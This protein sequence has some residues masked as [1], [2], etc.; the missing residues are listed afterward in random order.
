M[1]T[2]LSRQEQRILAAARRSGE[3]AE[4]WQIEFDWRQAAQAAGLSPDEGVTLLTGLRR[5]GYVGA[6]GPSR[7]RLTEEGVEAAAQIRS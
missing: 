5:Y 3:A 6:I 1:A 4:S 2:T 7:A